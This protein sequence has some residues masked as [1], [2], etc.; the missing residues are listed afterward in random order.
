VIK[1]HWWRFVA[2]AVVAYVLMWTVGHA[3]SEWAGWP[4]AA[5]I[6]I[7]LVIN[8]GT[9]VGLREWWTDE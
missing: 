2:A 4:D 1:I 6:L 7:S 9:I 3:L 5:V 8:V